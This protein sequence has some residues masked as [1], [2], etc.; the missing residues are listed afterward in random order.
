MCIFV[1]S[2]HSWEELERIRVWVSSGWLIFCRLQLRIKVLPERS[3]QQG[4]G[5]QINSWSCNSS[6][7]ASSGLG[8]SCGAP[9]EIWSF[10]HHF[11]GR[12]ISYLS[13]RPAVR[14]CHML[15]A[16]TNLTLPAKRVFLW[17]LLPRESFRLWLFF[18]ST[19]SLE[20][21]VPTGFL[22]ACGC[23]CATGITVTKT[24]MPGPLEEKS[25]N[26]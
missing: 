9:K 26:P 18:K 25:G 16:H 8:H 5:S 19:V 3:K 21:A 11:L 7:A 17:L 12:T 2:Q 22:I 10:P 15:E 1:L 24:C 4:P 20:Y 14:K 23:F 13:L 6:L